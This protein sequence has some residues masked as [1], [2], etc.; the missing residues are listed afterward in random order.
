MKSKMVVGSL[1]S[2]G[3]ITTLSIDKPTKRRIKKLA[4]DMPLSHFVKG[5]FF[6]LIKLEGNGGQEALPGQER[7]VSQATIHSV[8]SKLDKLMVALS[9]N[10]ICGLFG[11]PPVPARQD[12]VAL[13]AFF[14]GLVDKIKRGRSLPV[15]SQSELNL[16]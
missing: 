15:S 8:S 7:E 14:Q 2:E 10:S 16:A 1:R 4:G 6:G 13:A 9:D 12:D 3:G 5:V 11:L